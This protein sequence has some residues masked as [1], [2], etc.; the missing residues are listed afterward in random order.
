MAKASG[1]RRSSSS[2][3]PCQHQDDVEEGGEE[4]SF[5]SENSGHHHNNLMSGY[6]GES[7][8][9][10]GPERSPTSILLPLGTITST[11]YMSSPSAPITGE[12]L[13]F[14]ETRGPLQVIDI[15]VYFGPYFPLVVRKT[16]LSFSKGR[17][18]KVLE[19]EGDDD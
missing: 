14:R 4:G 8:V 12:L 6:S 10:D 18:K 2:L 9:M 5:L 13:F 17:G 3:T 19:K 1:R 7:P 16:F 11:G 15:S